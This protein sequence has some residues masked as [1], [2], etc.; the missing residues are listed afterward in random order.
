MFI[1]MEMVLF[2]GLPATGKST[3][4]KE[5]FFLT[6]VR[7]NR[8]LLKTARREELLIKASLEGKTKFVVENTNLTRAVRANYIARAREEGFAVIGYFFD[9]P[10]IDA[11]QRN[12][13]RPEQE[14]VPAVAVWAANKRLELP[15]RDEG[16]DQLYRVK[17]IQPAGFS[18]QTL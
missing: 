13:L 18:V 15:S 11:V 5:R 10:A 4:Y 17:L 12:K 16:F 2:I 14:R 9:S 1:R 6:H 8:D 3:F 7:I